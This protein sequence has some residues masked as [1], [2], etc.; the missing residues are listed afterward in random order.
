MFCFLCGMT[1][2]CSKRE[3]PAK[4]IAS[5]PPTPAPKSA[6]LDTATIDEEPPEPVLRELMFRR[7]AWL[8]E[9]GGLPVTVTATGR[10]G[11]IRSKLYEVRKN[12]CT[13]SKTPGDPIGLYE[14]S[15]NLMV[16][17]WWDGRK[18]DR[19]PSPKGERISVMKD[20]SGVWVDCDY[21]RDTKNVCTKR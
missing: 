8:D 14:C 9:Q 2:A 11:K 6:P 12:E 7:Y 3:E 17:M 1:A 16:T 18:E 5:S 15:V 13:K 10:S 4:A 19:N 20:A 21:A